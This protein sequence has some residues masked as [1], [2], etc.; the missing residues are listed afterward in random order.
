MNEQGLEKLI[1]SWGSMGALWGINRSMARVHALL[2]ATEAPLTLDDIAD[3][4]E[5]SRGNVSMCLKD[6]RSWGVI[7]KIHERGDR[8]D[9][10]VTEPEVWTMFFRILSQRK[11]REFDPVLES[12]REALAVADE[13]ESE[14]VRAR[15]EEM[16]NLLVTLDKLAARFLVNERASRAMLSFLAGLPSF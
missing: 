10:F 3:R 11:Q 7:K 8:K 13:D 12:L 6:L 15:L 14:V 1:E 9:Y 16:T 4:L 5:I 2:I